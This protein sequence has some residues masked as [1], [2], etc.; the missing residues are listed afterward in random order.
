M[1]KSRIKN[2]FLEELSRT[3]IV[4][5]ACERVG[6]SRQT[7]YRWRLE[8][9]WFAVQA[10]D[11][12]EMGVEFVNDHAE[13]NILNG[14]K[15]GEMNATKYWL[16]ARHKAYKRPFP[17]IIIQRSLSDK[18]AEELHIQEAHEKVKQWLEEWEAKGIP[19]GTRKCG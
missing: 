6:I 7:Y 17:K 5:V 3:P 10:N 15:Q 18:E 16:S 9:Q 8:D 1:K 4:Q 19:N 11:S 14:I 2:K 13:S 12:L